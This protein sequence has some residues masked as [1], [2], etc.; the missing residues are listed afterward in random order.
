MQHEVYIDM[1]FLTNFLMDF[2]ILRLAGRLFCCRASLL[3]TALAAALGALSSCLILLYLR[4]FLMPVPVLFHG[5]TALCMVKIGCRVRW[6]ALFL[7]VLSAFYMTAFLLGGF[8]DVLS[9]G[10]LRGLTAFLWMAGISYVL[11][12]AAGRFREFLKTKTE[13][14][15][16]VELCFQG[17]KIQIKGFYDTGNRLR[18]FASRKPVCVISAEALSELLP[19]GWQAE[20][21]LEQAAGRE[22]A[23]EEVRRLKPHVL[24][25]QSVGNTEGLVLAVTLDE[26]RI[27]GSHQTI[28]VEQPVVA[29]AQKGLL[30]E[31]DYQII[32]NAGLME[33]G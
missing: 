11:F 23:S 22:E 12:T 16:Q 29:V 32:L 7:R 21:L 25:F 8:W 2:L 24:P 9:G 1:V 17:K 4:D 28:Q 19:P 20:G 5:L 18:D 6:D 15:Y 3:R 14:M 27:S 26:M 31:K 33:N 13:H 10:R 30:A